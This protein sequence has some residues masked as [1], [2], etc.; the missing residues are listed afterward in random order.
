MD[1]FDIISAT[2]FMPYNPN[3]NT[4][5]DIGLGGPSTEYSITE[6]MPDQQFANIPSIWWDSAGN[7]HRLPNESVLL[8]AMYEQMYGKQ[9][10]R[11]DN[12]NTAV[13][14]A[15]HRSPQGGASHK[16]L[17]EYYAKRDK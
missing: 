9:F 4:P 10:P 8:A 15:Q 1:E 12:P 6:Q 13:E 16:P 3:V 2:R 17:A 7:P 14:F 5:R 11:Y